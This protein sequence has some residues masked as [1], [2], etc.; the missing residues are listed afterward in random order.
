MLK[1]T[2]QPHLNLESGLPGFPSA[3]GLEWLSTTFHLCEP[4]TDVEDFKSW[5]ED[6]WFNLAMGMPHWEV[7]RGVHD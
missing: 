1:P 2:I 6:T 5:I 7:E 3:S 4:L